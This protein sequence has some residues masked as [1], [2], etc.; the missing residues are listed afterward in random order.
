M[1]ALDILILL[2]LAPMAPFVFLGALP[3]EWLPWKRWVW[4]ELPRSFKLGM[5][6]YMFYVAF[7]AW[8]FGQKWWVVVSP[9]VT[10]I[11]LCAWSI[12]EIRRPRD[13]PARPNNAPDRMPGAIATRESNRP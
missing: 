8:H 10:G 1:S 4:N 9:A 2:P 11:A 5:G 6:P 7:V 3:W 12:R 13:E